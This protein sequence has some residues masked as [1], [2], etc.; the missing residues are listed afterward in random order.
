MSLAYL[1][2]LKVQGLL[3]PAYKV[4]EISAASIYP[5]GALL[6]LSGSVSFAFVLFQLSTTS[7][8]KHDLFHRY[9]SGLFDL[10]KYLD[11]LKEH[12]PAIQAARSASLRLKFV[13]FEDFPLMDWDD[14]LEAFLESLS[15]EEDVND[16]SDSI[17][18]RVLAFFA[19]IEEIVSDIGVMCVRQVILGLHVEIVKKVVGLLVAL[20]TTLVVVHL[21]PS[22]HLLLVLHATPI[23]FGAMVSLVLVQIARYLALEYRDQVTFTT[24]D[25]ADGASD[26]DDAQQIVAPDI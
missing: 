25:E 22:G 17:E 11:Q 3:D 15:E 9:K 24:S 20:V 8:R 13:Q 12:S 4:A 14:Y 18:K 1:V 26:R 19:Y 21:G 23:F 5:I 6:A 7:A 16:T 2:H 10:D